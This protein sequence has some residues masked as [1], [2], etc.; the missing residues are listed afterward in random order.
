MAA[1][2]AS[3]LPGSAASAGAAN[4]GKEAR[5]SPER[6]GAETKSGFAAGKTDWITG[7]VTV[8][9]NVGTGAAMGAASKLAGIKEIPEC[10]KED[11]VRTGRLP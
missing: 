10:E 5:A 11:P 4:C 6:T 2:A 8:R 7:L 3:T 9:P 1:G